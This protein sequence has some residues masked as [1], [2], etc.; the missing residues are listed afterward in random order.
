[1]TTRP[2]SKQ[3]TMRID[4]KLDSSAGS[5]TS[6]AYGSWY[7]VASPKNPTHVDYSPN[8][9]S[10]ILKRL[11]TPSSGS[12]ALRTRPN[13]AD[14]SSIGSTVGQNNEKRPQTS[15]AFN[16][17]FPSVMGTQVVSKH[18]TPVLGFAGWYTGR[19]SGKI[20]AINLHKNAISIADPAH[21]WKAPLHC[22]LSYLES[23]PMAY[24]ELEDIAQKRFPSLG[25][26]KPVETMAV[27]ELAQ[28]ILELRKKLTNRFPAKFKRE[29]NLALAFSGQDLRKKG[30]ISSGHFR[31]CLCLLNLTPSDVQFK[32]LC[33]EYTSAFSADSIDYLQFIAAICDDSNNP[34]SFSLSAF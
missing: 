3:S 26:S 1:M 18:L 17:T 5:P 14:Y 30:V 22:N 33:G 6:A 8:S 13:S 23:L 31:H 24:A 34:E 29:K 10:T 9:L 4:A 28:L 16:S 12:E 21:T 32:L 19:K 25:Q 15:P 11:P 2:S 20:G 7:H 27:E